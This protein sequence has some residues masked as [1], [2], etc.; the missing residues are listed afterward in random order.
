MQTS[1][2]EVLLYSTCMQK[3][4]S[5]RD[6]RIF[7]SI[8]A[9]QH[10]SVFF[11]MFGSGGCPLSA[12]INK[13]FNNQSAWVGPR[14]SLDEYKKIDTRAYAI[15]FLRFPKHIHISRSHNQTTV[16]STFIWF[17][18]LYIYIICTYYISLYPSIILSLYYRVFAFRVI[19]LTCKFSMREVQKVTRLGLRLCIPRPHGPEGGTAM[20]W[21]FWSQ[22]S[23]TQTYWASEF[24]E[25]R[26]R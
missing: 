17:I 11:D 1:R 2:F 26:T 16:I 13:S 5:K 14:R 7:G 6:P 12:L 23:F 19:Q 4:Y 22:L 20:P 21:C 3:W 9:T 10:R 18:S 24:P 25:D 8:W 15:L